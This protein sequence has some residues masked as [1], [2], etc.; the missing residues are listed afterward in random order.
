M[1]HNYAQYLNSFLGL[2][3]DDYFLCRIVGD[4]AQVLCLRFHFQFVVMLVIGFTIECNAQFRQLE[5]ISALLKR[6]FMKQSQWGTYQ[7]INFVQSL[8]CL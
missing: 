2:P 8:V 7:Q 4:D 6:L 3:A 5:D 1:K